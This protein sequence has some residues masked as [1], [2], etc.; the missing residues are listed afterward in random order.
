MTIHAAARTPPPDLERPES[1]AFGIFLL[2]V[3]RTRRDGVYRCRH[4]TDVLCAVNRKCGPILHSYNSDNSGHG[5]LPG[6]GTNYPNFQTVSVNEDSIEFVGVDFDLGM[7][8]ILTSHLTTSTFLFD[9]AFFFAADSL[10]LSDLARLQ[11]YG[12]FSMVQRFATLSKQ[13]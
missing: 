6:A 11:R 9:A 12:G 8:E 7:E 1:S 10:I 3:V 2:D 13:S 4:G 5:N